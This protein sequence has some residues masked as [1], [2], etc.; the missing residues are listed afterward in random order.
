VK[1]ASGAGDSFVAGM[2][3]GIAADRPINDSFALGVA[4][5][6]AA[7]LTHGTRLCT[8]ADTERLFAEIQATRVRR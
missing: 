8:R 6:S 5:G 3:Y 4:A 7:V 2:V 1:S